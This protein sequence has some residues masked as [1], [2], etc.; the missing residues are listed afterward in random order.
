MFVS[1]MC[2][3][4]ACVCGVCPSSLAVPPSVPATEEHKKVECESLSSADTDCV[5]CQVCLV[6][7]QVRWRCVRRD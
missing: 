6:L 7:D 5:K 3:V 4:C 2:G 1:S